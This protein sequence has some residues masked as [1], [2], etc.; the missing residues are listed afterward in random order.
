MQDWAIVA[1]FAEGK[2]QAELAR[3]LGI[4]QPAVSKRLRRIRHLARGI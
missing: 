3:E 1:G 4:T 2:S